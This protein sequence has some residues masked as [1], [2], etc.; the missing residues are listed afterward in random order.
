MPERER[1][2][3]E[4]YFAAQ[5]RKSPEERALYLDEVCGFDHE[6]RQR[7]EQLLEAYSQVGS[8]LE[9]PHG[10]GNQPWSSRAC[11]RTVSTTSSKVKPLA[12]TS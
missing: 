3:E 9:D 8:F 5:E 12:P 11:N 4:I 6:V 7:V 1:S 10:P 2:L